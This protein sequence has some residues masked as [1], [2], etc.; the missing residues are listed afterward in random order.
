MEPIFLYDTTLRDGTQGESINF[1]AQEKINIAKRLDELGIHYIEGGWPGSNPRDMQFFELARKTAFSQARITAF[2]ATRRPGITPAQDENLQALIAS[3]TQAVTL[4]G[5]S[6]DLHV[7][8]MNNTLEENLKMISESIRYLKDQ[9]REVI[10]D[11]EHFFDGYKENPDYAMQ[12]LAAAIE[13]GANFLVLCDTN[14][15][16]LHYDIETIVQRVHAALADHQTPHKPGAGVRLGIHAHN[17]CASAVANTISAIRAGAVMVQGTINGYGERCGNADM[18]SIIPILCCKMNRPCVSLDQLATLKKVSRYVSE[19][20]N[21]TP[22]NSRPFVGRS[23]FAHKGGIHVSAIVKQPKAYEHMEPGI[24]GNSRRVLVSD[25][26][27]KT[28]VEYKARELGVS[29]EG[30]GVD[31]REIVN[32]IKRLEQEGFQFDV[33]DGS[34]KI[35]LQKLTGQFK[36]LFTLENYRISMEKDRDEHAWAHAITKVSVE[37]QKEMTTAEGDGPVNALDNALRKVMKKF[38]PHLG[39]DALRLVDYKVRVIDGR[40]ATA[41]KVRVIID[42]R[43]HEDIWTTTGVSTDIIEA[44][45]QALSDSFQYKLSK[46][47]LA[48]ENS[49]AVESPSLVNS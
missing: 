12:T 17:D 7:A 49:S 30:N 26:S 10:Y 47:L 28:N 33:A 43:D 29:L 11:A 39:L 31:S 18:T 15:G 19:T 34:L 16:T 21:M 46:D 38:Y 1:S 23:A 37:G 14:G 6:W 3:G 48:V 5:K 24:V 27:G 41:A 20:A 13:S 9:D 35:L 44:S 36:P 45:W 25:M 42:S 22:L 4:V 2:G 8:I 32:E 40:D